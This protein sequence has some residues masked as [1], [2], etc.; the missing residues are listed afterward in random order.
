MDP[1]DDLTVRVGRVAGEVIWFVVKW[2]AILL[3]YAA[4]ATVRWIAGRPAQRAP[5]ALAVALLVSAVV[6][7]P[8]AILSASAPRTDSAGLATAATSAPTFSAATPAATPTAM[9]EQEAIQVTLSRYFD[10]VNNHDYDT[11]WRQF[12]PQE[13]ARLGSEQ[14]YIQ[15]EATT[16]V[17][18]TML[19]GIVSQSPGVDSVT[20]SFTSTQSPANS[21][22]GQPCDNWSLVYTVV[23]TGGTWLIDRAV[24]ENGSGYRPC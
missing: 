17:S 24:G 18:N 20:L 3:Y 2:T 11:A 8:V 23:L 12:T 9:S 5:I 14:Q 15:G 22:D 21:P 4:E 13:Q 1:E 7:V 19:G 16:H 6:A 10:A